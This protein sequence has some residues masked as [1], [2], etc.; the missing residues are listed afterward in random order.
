MCSATDGWP[1][2]DATEYAMSGMYR[3]NVSVSALMIAGS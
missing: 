1:A 2:Y 3:V